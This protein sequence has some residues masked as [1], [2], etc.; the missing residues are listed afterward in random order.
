MI[1]RLRLGRRLW[2]LWNG[3]R[4]G[5]GVVYAQSIEI[6]NHGIGI[7]VGPP[8]AALSLAVV[9]SKCLRKASCLPSICLQNSLKNR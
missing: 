7:I 3:L 4:Y 6:S 8:S 2:S 9:E 5:F 1:I